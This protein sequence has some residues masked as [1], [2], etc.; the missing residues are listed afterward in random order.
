M[1]QIICLTKFESVQP[2]SISFHANLKNRINKTLENDQFIIKLLLENENKLKFFN[3]NNKRQRKKINVYKNYPIAS[4]VTAN[5][6]RE[7]TDAV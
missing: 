4:I 6:A 3:K 1:C 2:S 7:E 5:V